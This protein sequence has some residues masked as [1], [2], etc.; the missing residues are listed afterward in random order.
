MSK[1]AAEDEGRADW[2]TQHS[3]IQV[4]PN[5]FMFAEFISANELSE[6]YNVITLFFAK[7]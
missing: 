4:L 3:S 2:R 5:G 6:S 1:E 7:R